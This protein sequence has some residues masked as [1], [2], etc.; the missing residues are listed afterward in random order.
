MNLN[1]ILFTCLIIL[2]SFVVITAMIVRYFDKKHTIQTIKKMFPHWVLYPTINYQG[3][4]RAELISETEAESIINSSD[5]FALY[6]EK[7]L[8]P[9]GNEMFFYLVIN[10]EGVWFWYR[11][12]TT[13]E[14]NCTLNDKTGRI[15][16][17]K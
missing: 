4:F 5:T 15:K 6:P 10:F 9:I 3:F 7:E 12:I 13:T 17:I 2:I 14:I 16:I 11:F 1:L 8:N